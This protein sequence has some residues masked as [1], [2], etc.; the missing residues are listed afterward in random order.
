MVTMNLRIEYERP[1]L[2]FVGVLQARASALARVW[3]LP[4][5]TFFAGQRNGLND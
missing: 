5:A 3:K 1:D 2:F 4:V